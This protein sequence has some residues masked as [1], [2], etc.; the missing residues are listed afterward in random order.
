MLRTVAVFSF[1]LLCLFQW[2]PLERAA[3]LPSKSAFSAARST[4]APAGGFHVA[5]NRIIDSRGRVFL[6]RG[7]ETA[8]FRLDTAAYDNHAGLDYGVLS[9]TTLSAI[10]LRFNLNAVRLPVDVVESTRPGY[11][12]ALASVVR[13]ANDMDLLV[14]LAPEEDN[15]APDRVPAKARERSAERSSAGPEPGLADLRAEKIK[16]YASYFKNY[17]NVMF[18]TRGNAAGQIAAIRSAGAA[19]PVIAGEGNTSEVIDPNVIYEVTPALAASASEAARDAEFAVS[20]HAPVM[21]SGLD[22]NLDNA[23]ELDNAQGCST[24][25]GD[26]AQ[27]SELLQANLN[28]F[29]QHAISWTISSFVPGKLIQELSL[30][31]ATT[32]EY[33][34]VCGKPDAIRAGIGRVLQAHMRAS[35]V[36]E[37]FVVS[38]AGGLD[39]A[40]G[41]YALAYGP[42]M[43]D[44]DI[45]A[46]GFQ[47]P[48]KLGGISIQITDANGVTRPAGIFWA[49]EGWGQTNF[50][51]PDASALGPARM[52]VIRE[53]GSRLSANISIADAAP[54]FLTGHSCRGPAIGAATQIFSNGRT[55]TSDISSCKGFDCRTMA[56]PVSADATTR[57]RIIG[58]GFRHAASAAAIDMR[59]AGVRVPVVSYGPTEYPGQD[60]VT[61]EIPAQLYGIGEADLM[62]HLNGRISNATRIR[63]GKAKPVS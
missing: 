4:L 52:T 23:L 51:V 42:V 54:G 20:R 36:R 6:I 9:A 41:A 27:A 24:I 19:Q 8:P 17:P 29:D 60:Q 38:A 53:D 10:R 44:H 22:L 62:C 39:I 25:P 18:E 12:A 2:T 21:A 47:A 59:I 15:A 55:S 40:R 33:G 58:S 48:R 1:A 7:T 46:P 35:I 26:P 43:A 14:I 30:H 28:Y 31:D 34:W 5:G 45:L 50:V 37:F 13:R 56:I 3:S 61:V 11:F 49:S 32:L 63:I 57:V 16:D